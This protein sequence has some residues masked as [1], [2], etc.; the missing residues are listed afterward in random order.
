MVSVEGM[1]SN[2]CPFFTVNFSAAFLLSSD[3]I[4]QRYW[5]SGFILII[6]VNEGRAAP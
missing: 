1:S 5:G 2:I 3:Q 6:W 4:V